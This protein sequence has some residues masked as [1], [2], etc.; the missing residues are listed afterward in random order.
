[1]AD[2]ALSLNWRVFTL[3]KAGNRSEEFEDA[4]AADPVTGR[5]AI[6]DGASESSFAGVWAEML[7]KGFVEN[8]GSWSGWLPAGRTAWQQKFQGTHR[9]GML[10][11]K[12]AKGRLPPFSASP[13]ADRAWVGKRSPW[14]IAA[15]FMCVPDVCCVR[16]RSKM[17]T[18]SAINRNSSARSPRRNYAPLA[19]GRR[20]AGSGLIAADDG[21]AGPVVSPQCDR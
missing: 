1:M 8:P 20:L 7:V 21:R 5:F 12:C 13:L 2:V 9:P 10:K 16:S 3:A 19:F 6:A 11:K 15:C 4:Y 17:P 14:E 18:R